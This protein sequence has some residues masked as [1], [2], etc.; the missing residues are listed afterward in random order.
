MR[1]K[2]G[3]VYSTDH[4]EYNTTVVYP[5]ILV[6]LPRRSTF[7]YRRSTFEYQWFCV[8]RLALTAASHWRSF[9]HCALLHVPGD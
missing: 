5:L 4:P 8:V 2:E 7:E 3:F 9:V 6:R 1:G